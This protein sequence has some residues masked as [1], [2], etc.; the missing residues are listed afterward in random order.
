MPG[1]WAQLLLSA[2][3]PTSPVISQQLEPNYSLA[4]SYTEVTDTLRETHTH[5]RT[6]NTCILLLLKETP[7][8]SAL[9]ILF[10]TSHKG[11]RKY[12]KL[13]SF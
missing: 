11:L 6:Q 8:A 4:R 13:L 5:I 1:S 10:V 2:L 3:P 12:L 9:L 7:V